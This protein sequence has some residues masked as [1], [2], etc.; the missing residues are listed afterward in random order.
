MTKLLSE[1]LSVGFIE[2][3]AGGGNEVVMKNVEEF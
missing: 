1:C 3:A 2:S